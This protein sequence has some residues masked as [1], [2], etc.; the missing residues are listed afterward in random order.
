MIPN[1]RLISDQAEHRGFDVDP[2]AGIAGMI[3]TGR[4]FSARC[5]NRGQVRAVLDAG[6]NRSA[7]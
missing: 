5:R 2:L 7:S 6:V 4:L 1:L 3:I